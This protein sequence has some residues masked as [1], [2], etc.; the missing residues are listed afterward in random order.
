MKK[1]VVPAA[2]CATALAAGCAVEPGSPVTGEP[3][4]L[5]GHAYAWTEGLSEEAGASPYLAFSTE[6]A[7]SGLAGCN[8][9]IG[10]VRQDGIRVDFSRLGT[11]RMLCAPKVMQSERKFLDLLG[12]TAFATQSVDADGGID[13]WTAEGEKIVTLRPKR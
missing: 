3:A 1:P 5:N 6:G 13:L 12:R 4:L 9:I 7:V 2:L 11:T 8:G 10:E